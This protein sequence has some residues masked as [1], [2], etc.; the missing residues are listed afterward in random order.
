MEGFRLE[1]WGA[2]PVWTEMPVP[3][4]GAGEVLVRV[5]A[6]GVGLTVLNALDGELS[7]ETDGLP[8]VPGHEFV[9]RVIAAGSSGGAEKLI[10]RRVVAYFYL[11]C[12]VCPECMNARESLCRNFAGFVGVHC[13][14]GY[15][16]YAVLPAR[17]A[18][19]VPEELDPTAATVIP[20]AVATPV[21][22]C[23]DRTKLGLNDRV[24]VIGAGGGVGIHM[25][26]VAHLHG[27]RVAGLEIE[28]EKLSTLEEL[29]VLPIRSGPFSELDPHSIWPDGTP[30]VIVDFVG[31]T[32]SLNWSVEAL[33]SGGTLVVLTPF[34]G[35]ELRV[36]PRNAVL[37]ELSIVGAR[38]A[39]RAEVSM[40]ADLV[41]SG[42]IRSVI[43]ERTDAYSVP[44]LHERLRNGKLLGR[45]ALCWET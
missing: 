36:D 21:H 2:E 16:P 34:R 40:A 10:G 13:D 37:R 44:A 27:A 19:P 5:E 30:S 9:G 33:A 39:S 8:V 22:I 25:V 20:D 1:A 3:R 11:H 35:R 24:L 31:S 45:G 28:E 23:R 42:R 29:G 43:G 7:E 12:G 4:P 38:Y 26:Q 41:A 15:A 6:C 18:I 17:N 14:G 32:D